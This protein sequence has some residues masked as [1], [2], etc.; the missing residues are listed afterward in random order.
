MK[1]I[2][3]VIE[4]FIPETNDVMNSTKIGFKVKYIMKL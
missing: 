2:G 4:V 1:K 3:K